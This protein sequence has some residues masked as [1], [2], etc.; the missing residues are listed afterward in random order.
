MVVSSEIIEIVAK[1][2]D[3][4]VFIYCIFWTK[5]RSLMQEGNRW[6]WSTDEH[7]WNILN[8]Q[9][10]SVYDTVTQTINKLTSQELVI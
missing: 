5:G 6:A 10:Q 8:V 4:Y 7:S 2:S 3:I 9:I 1:S